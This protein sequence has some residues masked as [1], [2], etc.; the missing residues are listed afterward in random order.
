MCQRCGGF[1]VQEWLVDK[2]DPENQRVGGYRCVNCGDL[3]EPLLVQH[4]SVK[5][6]PVKFGRKPRHFDPVQLTEVLS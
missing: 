5:A 6:L 3:T 2:Y 1:V 4:R